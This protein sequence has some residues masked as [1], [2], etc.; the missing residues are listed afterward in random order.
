MWSERRAVS[1]HISRMFRTFGASEREKLKVDSEPCGFEGRRFD[2][3][4]SPNVETKP[5]RRF[6]GP[7][8]L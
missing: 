2:S 1:T 7:R 4:S 6:R 5:S 8:P 3:C